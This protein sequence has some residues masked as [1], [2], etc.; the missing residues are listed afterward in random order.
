MLSTKESEADI[1]LKVSSQLSEIRDSFDHRID[2]DLFE[3]ILSYL[4]IEEKFKYECVSKR[5]Q[6]LVFNGQRVL[7]I[8][9]F[10]HKDSLAIKKLVTNSQMDV[11][12]LSSL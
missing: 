2:D 11:L 10:D 8:L 6:S 4:P 1:D 5:F 12:K 9:M 3:L 7:R